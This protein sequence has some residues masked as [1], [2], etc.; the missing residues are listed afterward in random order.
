MK[1]IK[2]EIIEASFLDKNGKSVNVKDVI[3]KSDCWKGPKDKWIITFKAAKHLAK[4]AGISKNFEVEES[5]NII[6][7]YKNDLAYI[8]R[9]TIKCNACASK[10]NKEECVHGERTLTATGEANRKNTSHRGN[11]YLRKMSE[12]RGYIIA[13]L[14][15]LDLYSAIY[16]E[17]E[18]E[19]FEQKKE[20]RI[21]PG[22]RDFESIVIEINAILE[23]KTEQELKKVGRKIKAGVKVNKYNA[24]QLEYLRNL[25]NSNHAKK[26]Q[27]F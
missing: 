2:E 11:D 12:K 13:V 4:L 24:K 10:L 20:P 3:D 14:E 7:D 6:P 15:H 18:S 1:E 16:C 21:M 17:D 25:Y 19:E 8:V 23:C 26:L 9:V 27:S 22:T 5:K